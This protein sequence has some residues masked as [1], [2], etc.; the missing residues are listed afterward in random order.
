MLTCDSDIKYK[1]VIAIFSHKPSENYLSIDSPKNELHL[2]A[3]D[4][5]QKVQKGYWRVFVIWLN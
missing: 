1:L 2:K 3:S 4:Q 5:G